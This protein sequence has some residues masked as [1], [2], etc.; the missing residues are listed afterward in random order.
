MSSDPDNSKA[1]RPRWFSR[2]ESKRR[3]EFFFLAWNLVWVS[4]F[5]WI[6]LSRVFEV[7]AK[8]ADTHRRP[9]LG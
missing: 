3:G 2:N 8:V 1:L 4:I 5:A 6:V 9:L 7:S